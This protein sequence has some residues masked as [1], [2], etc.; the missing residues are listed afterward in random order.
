MKLVTT[1]NCVS[2]L[3]V[4]L[5]AE[6]QKIAIDL[7]IVANA[8]KILLIVNEDCQLFSA[9]SAVWYLCSLGNKKS[10]PA[11][12]RWLDWESTILNPEVQAFITKGPNKLT[13][14]LDHLER[15][16]KT[17]FILGVSTLPQIKLHTLVTLILHVLQ[18]SLSA[19]DIVI[20]PTLT[21]LS[22]GSLL[23]KYP[24]IYKLISTIQSTSEFKV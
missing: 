6:H 19:A 14:A 17:K 7:E 9:N 5:A 13:A 3:K 23:E 8:G 18:S 24:N 16:L 12:D 22:G 11:V 20:F 15:S 10:N 4:L 21:L 2:G 1:S